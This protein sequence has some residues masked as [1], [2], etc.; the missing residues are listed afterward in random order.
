MAAGFDQDE[1]MSRFAHDS[2]LLREVYMHFRVDARAVMAEMAEQLLHHDAD[3]V[4]ASAHWLK[5]MLATFAARRAYAL[6]AYLEQLGRS[7]SLSRAAPVLAAL[8][9]ELSALDDELSRLL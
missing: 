4:A 7:G 2:T 9:R 1:L 3:G 6:A 5:K 8:G